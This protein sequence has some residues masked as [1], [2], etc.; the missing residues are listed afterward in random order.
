MLGILNYNQYFN[1]KWMFPIG[2][3]YQTLIWVLSFGLLPMIFLSMSYLFKLKLNEH[4][5]YVLFF[6]F[7]NAIN[8]PFP[9]RLIDLS[10]I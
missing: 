8:F 6:L 7:Y 4:K 2:G 1:L 3:L 9:W 10:L 5:P